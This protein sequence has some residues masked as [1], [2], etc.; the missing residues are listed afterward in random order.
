M[1][2]D[3]FD[4]LFKR[5]SSG[6]PTGTSWQDVAAELEALGKTVSEVLRR[7]WQGADTGSGLARLSEVV[8]AA[9]DELNRAVDGTPEAV[10]AR[11]Q[12]VDLRDGLRAAVDRASSELRPE[13]LN[14]LRQANA[15]LRRRS[16]V[17][18]ASS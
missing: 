1:N 9:I 4:E 15:E 14:L 16:G 11:D 7:A 13:L 2:D 17:D 10:Q 8:S 6:Q 5:L 3:D 12:M 18:D